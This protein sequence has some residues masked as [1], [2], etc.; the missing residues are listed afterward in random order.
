MREKFL[1]LLILLAACGITSGAT[2]YM[3]NNSGDSVIIQS[4]DTTGVIKC[5]NEIKIDETGIATSVGKIY[6]ATVT[7][8]SYQNNKVYSTGSGFVY[9][10]DAKYGYIMTNHHVIDG[11]QGLKITMSNDDVVDGEVLG[12]DEYLD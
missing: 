3:I 6:D 10:K 2:Y 12:S 11:N 7:I 9:K 8:Q 5:N 1:F 4:T